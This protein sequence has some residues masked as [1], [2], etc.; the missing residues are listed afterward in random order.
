MQI[1]TVGSKGQVSLPK[2][3]LDRLGIRKQTPMLVEVA[4]DGAIVLR[5]AAVYPLEIYSPER[6][7]EFD[8]ADRLSPAEDDDLDAVRRQSR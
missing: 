8:D 5:P 7:R 6:I 4:P 3:I 1:V 2:A